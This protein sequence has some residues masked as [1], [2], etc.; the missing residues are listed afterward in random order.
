MV[1]DCV[2]G[3]DPWES[4]NQSIQKE[5]NPDYSLEGLLLKLKLQYFD[6]LMRRADLLKKT[7]MLGKIEGKRRRGWQRMRWLDGITNS[8][9]MSLSRLQKTVKDRQV[10]GVARIRTRLS[11]W[12]T[13]ALCLNSS[14]IPSPPSEEAAEHWLSSQKAPF[15][16]WFISCL[17]SGLFCQ[18]AQEAVTSKMEFYKFVALPQC[19]PKKCLIALYLHD[20]ERYQV[21]LLRTN[22][23][24]PSDFLFLPIKSSH[25]LLDKNNESLCNHAPCFKKSV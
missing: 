13:T 21:I 18:R 9:D 25:N 16:L 11:D 4:P 7:L 6:R 23:L 17:V 5:I 10:H 14:L 8:M 20:Y 3:E 12:R 22:D 24:L 1:S 15:T 2:A 19:P